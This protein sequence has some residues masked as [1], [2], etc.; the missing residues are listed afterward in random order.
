MRRRNAI[1]SCSLARRFE[2]PDTRGGW[3]LSKHDHSAI[4]G[5]DLARKTTVGVRQ[6]ANLRGRPVVW[7]LGHVAGF[8][9]SWADLANSLGKW[10]ARQDSNLRPSA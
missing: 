4:G 9:E 1:P 7:G 6:S 3:L 2:E 8:G 10:R 5:P